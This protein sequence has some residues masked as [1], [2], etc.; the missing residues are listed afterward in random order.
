MSEF[1]K[2]ITEESPQ[3]STSKTSTNP[4]AANADHPEEPSCDSITLTPLMKF[5]ARKLGKDGNSQNSKLVLSGIFQYSILSLLS[6]SEWVAAKA[7]QLLDDS[8]YDNDWLYDNAAIKGGPGLKKELIKAVKEEKVNLG[9]DKAINDQFLK[10]IDLIVKYFTSDGTLED[11]EED[12]EDISDNQGNT[13]ESLTQA[14]IFSL[15][16]LERA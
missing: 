3:A 14:S 6:R 7:V 15:T 12:L 13:I 8:G 10:I 2:K 4:E 1:V 16:Q 9:K 11:E 5:I